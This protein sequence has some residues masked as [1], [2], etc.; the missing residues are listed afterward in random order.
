VG[1]GGEEEGKAQIKAILGGL[2]IAIG[3]TF[4]GR[5]I[6]RALIMFC[7]TNANRP[8][9]VRSY[10]RVGWTVSVLQVFGRML[11]G[12]SGDGWMGKVNRCVG[13]LELLGVTGCSLNGMGYSLMVSPPHFPSRYHFG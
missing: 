11:G 10:P 7:N 5:A 9:W 2:G 4:T 8:R 6:L 12:G 1:E 3:C 13:L